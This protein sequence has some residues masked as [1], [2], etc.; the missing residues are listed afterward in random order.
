V[1]S[2]EIALRLYER[3]GMRIIR[4]LYTYESKLCP[5]VNPGFLS[6]QAAPPNPGSPKISE[7]KT[8][9]KHGFD[10]RFA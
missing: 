1:T 9:E 8:H 7:V 3:T 10:P 4:Q 2:L 6:I 5:G